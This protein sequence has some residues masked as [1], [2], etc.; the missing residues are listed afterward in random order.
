MPKTSG[1][2][3]T[4]IKRILVPTDLSERSLTAVHYGISL[5]LKH[6]GEVV[7]LHVVG[8]DPRLISAM[9]PLDREMLALRPW[10]PIGERAHNFIDV[11]L[12]DR[13]LVLHHF[14]SRHID[15]KRMGSVK[16]TR[17]IVVGDVVEEI[18]NVARRKKCDLIIMATRERSWIRR[19]IFGSVSD[20][21]SRKA[22]CSVLT[23]YPSG[24]GRH[25]GRWLLPADSLVLR[26]L[27]NHA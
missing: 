8:D 6:R 11:K 13:D 7:V 17:L 24:E 18:V 26:E 23:I 12:R 22:A 15:P 27:P 9:I 16:L 19:K 4:Q 2:S 5:A 3:A 20:K 1:K 10:F 25:N 21:V 14:L